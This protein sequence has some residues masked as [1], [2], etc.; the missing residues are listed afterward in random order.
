MKEVE[1]YGK[2]YLELEL[3][4]VLGAI[5]LGDCHEVEDWP[6]GRKQSCQ[7]KF[8]VE[9]TNRGERLVKQSTFKGKV[10]KAKKTTYAS[11]VK[12]IEIDGKVGHVELTKTMSHV[13]V[14]MQD[15]KYKEATFWDDEAKQI[16]SHFFAE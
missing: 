9:S 3:D 14:R 10:Y 13:G 7:M 16:A 1:I 15:G 12:I 5:D 11:R 4:D 2:K 6:W 8:S